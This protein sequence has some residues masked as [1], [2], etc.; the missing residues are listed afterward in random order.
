M[1]A[2][3]FTINLHTEDATPPYQV[4]VVDANDSQIILFNM[5]PNTMPPTFEKDDTISFLAVGRSLVSC[6]LYIRPMRV[7]DNEPEN[8]PY[9][10]VYLYSPPDFKNADWQVTLYDKTEEVLAG[11]IKIVTQSGYWDFTIAGTF[12]AVISSNMFNA[13]CVTRPLLVDP[14][15]VVGATK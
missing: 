3:L 15:C 6:T 9:E 4:S 10:V 2:Y 12:S 14:E 13:K 11:Y 8:L 5:P 7:H 1:T